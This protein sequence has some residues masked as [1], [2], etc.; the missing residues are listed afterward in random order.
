MTKCAQCI[1]WN[2]N[3]P[4]FSPLHIYIQIVLLLYFFM[5]T[6]GSQFR[7]ASVHDIYIFTS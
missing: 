6:L 7:K 1:I 5:N 3:L 4:H 2:R